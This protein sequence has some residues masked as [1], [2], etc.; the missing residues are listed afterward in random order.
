MRRA[1]RRPLA[2]ERLRHQF[3]GVQAA[4]HQR[5]G[6]AGAHQ[7]DGDR[8]RVVAVAGIDDADAVQVDPELFG[9]GADLRF[10]ADQDRLDDAFLERR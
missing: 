6:I 5:F 3:V 8:R 1:V 10:R 2:R 7:R 9:D 4:F